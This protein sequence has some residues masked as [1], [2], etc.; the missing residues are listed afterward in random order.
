MA[1]LIIRR[2]TEVDVT[3]VHGIEA[4]SFSTPWTLA[5]FLS[6]MREN[7]VARYLVIQAEGEVAGFAGVHII[8]DEGHITNIAVAPAYRGLGYGKLITLALM[9]YASNLGVSYLT[10]E[11]RKSNEKAKRLYA[12]LGFTPVGL[13]K[14]YYPDTGEDAL[15][16]ACDNL[17]DAQEDFEE[18]ETVRE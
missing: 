9:Q 8:L 1:E 15:L 5:M 17:P 3:A 16:M 18:P 7:K 14:N 4:A 10:L 6:E 12:S 11:V 2:M 13:R